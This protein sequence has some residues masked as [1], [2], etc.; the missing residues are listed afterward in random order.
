MNPSRAAAWIFVAA[1]L[2]AWLASAAGMSRSAEQVRAVETPVNSHP[3]DNLAADVQAQATRLRARMETAP[4]PQAPVRNPFAFSQRVDPR[5]RPVQ[6]VRA[7]AFVPPPPVAPAEPV[8]HLIGVAEKK[9]W[10][11]L[12]RTAMISTESDDLIMATAGQR[13]LGAYDVVAVGLDAVELR[14]IVSGATRRLAL[15]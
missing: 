6:P 3:V 5:P 15:R 2:G 10:E 9:V 12:V 8:L 13:I 14:D 1:V 11:S 7:Q 4:A